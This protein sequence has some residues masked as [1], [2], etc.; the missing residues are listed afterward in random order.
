MKKTNNID[1]QEAQVFLLEGKFG[2][3]KENLRVTKEG[4]IACSPHPE[5][6]GDK[7]KHPY[8]TVDFSESQLEMITPPL[9]SIA[10]AAGFMKT[11]H[12]V[13]N[14]NIGEEILW[15]SSMPPAL[16]TED[17]EVPMANFGELGKDHEDYRSHL[18]HTYGR[19]KQLISG[20]HFN[21]SPDPLLIQHLYQKSGELNSAD[22][23]QEL[24][25]KALRIMMKNRWMPLMLTGN[26]PVVHTSFDMSNWE[27]PEIGQDTRTHRF[28][29]SIRASISGYRN[30]EE[31]YLDYSNWDNF[32]KSV[33]SLVS[34]KKILQEKELYL[35][36]RIKKDTS[37]KITH[38][39]IRLLDLDPLSPQG[40]N[41]AALYLY[42]LYFLWALLSDEK[43]SAFNRQDQR[44]AYYNQYKVAC[45][46][47]HA[48]IWE[49]RKPEE[50]FSKKEKVLNWLE[51][52]ATLIP[53]HESYE[54]YRKALQYFKSLANNPKKGPTEVVR[55][56][57]H[58]KGYIAYHMELAEKFKAEGLA[59]GYRFSG[60]EDMELS[61][62]LMLREAIRRGVKFE[63]LDRAANFVQFSKGDKTEFVQQATKTSLDT[64]SGVLMMENKIVTKHVLHQAEIQVPMGADFDH[65]DKAKASFMQF[66]GK[67][68][69]IKPKTTNFGLGISI[70][71]E[72]TSKKLFH[73]AVE[74]AF[75]E[76]N[77]I[78]IE[79]FI[80]GRE[81]RIFIIGEE[82]VGIL[83]RV[84]ANV[85]GDG[86]STI[87][88]LV[89][90]KNQDPL[91]GV[92]YRTPLEKIKL[93]APE[94]MFL[95]TQGL[96]FDSIPADGETVYLRENSNISTGGDSLDFTDDIHPSYKK[97]AVEAAKALGVKITG[98][99]MM[100]Q[101]IDQP[102]TADNYSIIEMNFNP[103][104]HIHCH[105]FRGK[106]RRLNAKMMDIL[107][108]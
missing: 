102:A 50:G 18:A 14:E 20:I 82:V 33:D 32:K 103:A 55:K 91:R 2:L 56:G 57:V 39:E 66:E 71:K 77:S 27:L 106:N 34:E 84:P 13:V 51:E 61:T 104:I 72:N 81:F 107:G 80:A 75:R 90:K 94:R 21:V 9:P 48:D 47:A 54:V 76:D 95:E 65:P 10:E 97:I 89:E 49:D 73:E 38:M 30:K 4:K 93:E 69:V 36:F 85:K 37:G 15:P 31:F 24:Y 5:D 46:G 41:E 12:E 19:K 1:Q 53:A 74:M 45:C 52:L 7:L 22:F 68:I 44:V 96:N 58:E 88:E 99:D 16:P 62:Q 23:E 29:H 60:L 59:K 92:G 83:H 105:P 78:L 17:G 64:Y 42:H 79:P 25:L 11:I 3:E 26:S 28:T 98:L 6:F 43:D 100:I 86:S 35:P 63:I 108:F 8:V 101:E 67:A 40:I 87:R 70:L